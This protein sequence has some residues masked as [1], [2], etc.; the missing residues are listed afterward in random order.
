MIKKAYPVS[1]MVSILGK[2]TMYTHIYIYKT[3][4]NVMYEQIVICY[5]LLKMS[6]VEAFSL[7]EY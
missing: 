1:R 4:I 3:S 5:L 7:K 2:I 6:H